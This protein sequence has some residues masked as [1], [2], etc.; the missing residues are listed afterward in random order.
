MTRT[1]SRSAILSTPVTGQEKTCSRKKK[2]RSKKLSEFD[3][4]E[5]KSECRYADADADRLQ[6][7]KTTPNESEMSRFRHFV[8][9]HL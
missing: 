3:V 8:E 9:V 7:S 1:F 2:N 5:Q 4:V 6:P